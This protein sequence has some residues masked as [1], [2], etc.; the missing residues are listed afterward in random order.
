MPPRFHSLPPEIQDMILQDVSRE[1]STAPYAVVCKSWQDFFERKNFRSLAIAKD[2]L[3]CLAQ[4]LVP[5]RQGF[6][7][8]IWYR[9]HLPNS[10][11]KHANKIKRAEKPKVTCRADRV[12]TQ[13]V[14]RLWDII[15]LW[16]PENRI[17]FELSVFAYDDWV[18]MLRRERIFER[19]L[20]AYKVHKESESR[21][22][23][24]YD[25]PHG[26]YVEQ[27]SLWGLPNADWRTRDHW[28]ACRRDL[29]GWKHI[30]LTTA[31][32]AS[33]KP[34]YKEEDAILPRVPIV[35]KFLIR[36]TQFRRMYPETLS[37]MFKSFENLEDVTIER[38]ASVGADE[39]SDWTRYAARAFAENL[40]A[41]VRTLSINGRKSTAFQDWAS[42]DVK[43]RDVLG[44]RLRQYSKNLEHMS[45]V[46]IIDAKDFLRLFI[47]FDS[48]ADLKSLIIWPHL[49][50]L[51][52]ST[53]LFKTR[54]RQR[55]EILLCCAA[56]AA[57]KMPKLQTLEI[58]SSSDPQCLFRYNIVEARAEITWSGPVV[59]STR[60]MKEWEKTSAW[61]DNV[62]VVNDF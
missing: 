26:P 24:H 39:E 8:H 25:N 54:Y 38:W 1:P 21:E 2:D 6:V 32:H 52:L 33:E 61:R 41:S 31:Q 13:S 57:R 17:T 45:V 14:F 15:S 48:D 18:G 53:N 47:I 43:L 22:P 60:I 10:N 51:T 40:P 35:S 62:G 49:K 37:L 19:D 34:Y 23:Y 27:Y 30:E 4:F 16:N 5:R 20:A 56:R 58:R 3:S 59:D 11:P 28:N 50:T 29:I 7:K 55:I 44:K 42:R 12:F 9:I 36:N 46:D